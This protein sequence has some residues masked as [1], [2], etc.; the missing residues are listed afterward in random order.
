MQALSDQPGHFHFRSYRDGAILRSVNLADSSEGLYNHP[1]LHVHRA[2]YHEVLVREF[3]RL[4]GNVQLNSEVIGIDMVTPTIHIKGQPDVL[5]DLIVAADGVKSFAR[6]ALLGRV[7]S[8]CPSGDM[9]LR[10]VITG[11][12]MA[13]HPDLGDMLD[14][15]DLH[16]W[17]GPEQHVVGYKLRGGD[18]FNIVI[19]TTDTLPDTVDM[20]PTQAGE[21]L[22]RVKGWDPKLQALVGLAEKG[23]K[24]RL[25]RV[26]E[27]ESWIHPS[28]KFVLLGDACHAT[29]PYL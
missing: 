26:N 9:S 18:L 20:S 19:A 14:S 3:R 10:C 23:S 29:M 15:H 6:Q 27:M 5:P 4:G 25:M 8:P 17:I 11:E 1:Y 13:G 22:E 28:S 16:Y 7:D 21:L 2:D 12:A 24:G